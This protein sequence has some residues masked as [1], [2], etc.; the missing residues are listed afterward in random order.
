MG[1]TIDF[2]YG[3]GSRYSYLAATQMERLERDTGAA[4]RW[5]PL[6]STALMQRRGMDPFAGSPASGQYEESYRF[7]DLSRWAAL[8]GIPLRDPDWD[9]LDW[10]RLALAAVA[11]DRLGVVAPFTRQ[12]FDAVFGAGE[13]PVGDLAIARIGDMAGLD[14]RRLVNLIDDGETARRHAANIDVALARGVFG[15]PSFVVDG[16]MF[17]GND[18]LLLLR[19]HLGA[20]A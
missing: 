17:W 3:I 12:L 6:F 7:T 13:P 2:F 14:G 9:A 10:K 20:G 1:R 5:R 4:V 18:R 11:A 19:H 8:Y 15:V 16:E